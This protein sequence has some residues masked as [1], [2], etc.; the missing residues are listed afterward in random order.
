IRL[1]KFAEGSEHEYDLNRNPK[2]K[3]FHENC[4]LWVYI[5]AETSEYVTAGKFGI[6]SRVLGP[7]GGTIVAETFAG[8]LLYDSHSFLNQDSRWKPKIGGGRF[9]LKE[10]VAYA[11]N[12]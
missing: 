2:F 6:E 10:F 8:L 7:V 1:E 3:C 9:G 4:P 12:K 5:L 11:L